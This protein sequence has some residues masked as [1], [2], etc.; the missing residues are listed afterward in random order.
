[1]SLLINLTPIEEARLVNAALQ[2]GIAPEELAEKLLREHLTPEPVTTAD[3]IRAKLRQWQKETATETF[4]ATSVRELFAHW[5]DEDAQMTDEEREAEDR[6]WEDVEK[7]IN[8]T[9][10]ELGMRQL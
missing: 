5:A 6:L 8:T 2:D 4:P 1:M 3:A 9:R 10:A 7:D